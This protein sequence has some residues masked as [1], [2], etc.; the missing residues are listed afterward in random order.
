MKIAI[1]A[2][3]GDRAPAQIVIGAIQAAQE[4]GAEIILVG[5]EEIVNAELAKHLP[6]GDS[7]ITIQHAEQ[8]VAMDDI[9]SQIVRGKRNS[10]LHIGLKLVK[11]GAADAFYSAGN[12]GAVMATAILMLRTLNGINRPA[13]ATVLPSLKG[14]SVM[15]D[16]GANVDSSPENYLHF[17]IM[18]SAYAK[19][20]LN[21]DNPTVGLLGIGEEDM[22]GN[23]TTKKAFSLLKDCKAINFIGNVEAK[24]L[25]K[26]KADVIVCDGFVGNIALKTSEAVASFVGT[27]LK[28]ELKR[29]LLSKIAALL[30]YPGLKRFKKRVDYEEYGGAPLLGVN[31]ICLIGHGSSGANAVKNAVRVAKELVGKNMNKSIEQ[32]VESSFTMLTPESNSN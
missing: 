19:S 11:D 18:G 1:D 15:L 16:S 3:G 30:M 29:T 12:T 2:M 17:A 14:H 26:G 9:P 21:V 28:E 23:E 13:I 7:R 31:G 25:Y 32:G 22:K 5:Q 20:I 27:M 10:S 24:E 4:Y 6:Q 8:V